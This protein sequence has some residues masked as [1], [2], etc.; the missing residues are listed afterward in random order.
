MI[1]KENQVANVCVRGIVIEDDHLVITE[2]K[3]RGNG[4]LIGGRI[5][6]G[7]ALAEAVGREIEEETGVKAT[8]ERLLYFSEN[9]FTFH[10]GREFHEY[11]WYFLVNAEREI[12]PDN[13]VFDNPDD[14][15]LI[16][17]R[18]PIT[19]EGLATVFPHFIKDYLPADYANNFANC[20]RAL[21]SDVENHV[22]DYSETIFG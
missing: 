21:H 9:I 7:E 17:K 2:W 12:C 20:P 18:V 13:L 19:A 3:S 14:P 6:Y 22:T 4:F 16:I 10:D 5:E 11:G 15:D 1:L 8:I